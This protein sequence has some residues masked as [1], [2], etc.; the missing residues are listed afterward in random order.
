MLLKQ[1]N[2]ELQD[3]LLQVR[4]HK[5]NWQPVLTFVTSILPGPTL[6]R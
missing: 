4:E 2:I 6:K 5:Q 1:R 3:E